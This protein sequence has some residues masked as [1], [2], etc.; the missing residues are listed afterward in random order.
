MQEAVLLQPKNVFLAIEATRI[1]LILQV[2]MQTQSFSSSH[3]T[4]QA[5]QR[6]KFEVGNS[7]SMDQ[8][9]LYYCI[10]HYFKKIVFLKFVLMND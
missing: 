8:F 5:Q 1:K 7:S 10:Y 3:E 4:V 9:L 6:N 2:Q